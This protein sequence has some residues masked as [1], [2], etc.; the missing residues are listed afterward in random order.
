MDPQLATLISSIVGLVTGVGALIGVLYKTRSE[1]KQADRKDD[2]EDADKFT[3]IAKGLVSPLETELERVNRSLIK[4]N[5]KLDKLV[6][7]IDAYLR[8]RQV[9]LV[10]VP[11]CAQCLASDVQFK[12]TVQAILLSGDTAPR[13]DI[14]RE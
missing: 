13:K 5:D 1:N 4:A 3:E 11:G 6:E 2:R 10:N 14:V 12:R 9:K 7:A 8:E